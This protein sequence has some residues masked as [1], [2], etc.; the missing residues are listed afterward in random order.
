MSYLI[1]VGVVSV[2]PKN[3]RSLKS[4]EGSIA[5]LVAVIVGLAVLIAVAIGTVGEAL[6]RKAHSQ[7][8]A[9]AVAL[10]VAVDGIDSGH[11]VATA[12]GATLVSTQIRG[13]DGDVVHVVVV[14]FRGIQSTA[15]AALLSDP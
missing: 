12:N 15:A 13:S 4:D 5:P 9:D 3:S 1:S 7:S 2:R 14:E 11:R 10:A 6:Q 8:T